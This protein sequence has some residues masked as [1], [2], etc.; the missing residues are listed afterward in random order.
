MEKA[1]G[2]ILCTGNSWRSQMAKAFLRKYAGDH[3][4][5]ELMCDQR[6]NNIT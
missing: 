1:K 4:T 2:L 3:F 6:T 5:A